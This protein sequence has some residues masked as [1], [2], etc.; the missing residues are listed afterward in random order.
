M[1]A[2]GTVNWGRI[3]LRGSECRVVRAAEPV[4][5]A[6]V[7]APSAAAPRPAIEGTVRGATIA[8]V[9]QWCGV[10]PEDLRITFAPE[11]DDILNLPVAGRTLEVRAAGD[12]DRLPIA[13]ALYAGDRTVA[14]KTIRTSVEVRRTVL[15]TASAQHRGDTIRD[16]DVTEE[17]RWVGPTVKAASREQAIGATVQG[18]LDARAVVTEDDVAP[19]VVVRKGEIVSIRCISGSIVLATRG[20]AMGPGRTGELAQ[21]QSLDGSKRTFFARID[22]KGRAIVSAGDAIPADGGAARVV[23]FPIRARRATPMSRALEALR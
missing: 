21:F 17:S 16:E 19:S 5:P 7:A 23:S 10:A 8:R 1:D 20:R 4:P 6:A 22:G 14:S 13:I 18:R 15:V 3:T 9:A 11:D 12:S 2:G